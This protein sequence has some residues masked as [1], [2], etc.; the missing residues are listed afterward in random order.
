MK[1]LLLYAEDGT[2]HR[3]FVHQ[4][5]ISTFSDA[6]RRVGVLGGRGS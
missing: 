5:R 1:T 3:A 4:E 6:G 2:Q